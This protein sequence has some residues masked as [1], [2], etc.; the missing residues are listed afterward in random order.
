MES[1]NVL[2]IPRLEASEASGNNTMGT[3][4]ELMEKSDD[5]VALPDGFMGSGIN[6]K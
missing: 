4:I 5:G 2:A 1:K 6:H 3:T